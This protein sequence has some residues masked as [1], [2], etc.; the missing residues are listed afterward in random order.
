[1]LRFMLV[2]VSM[3]S[4]GAAFAGCVSGGGGSSG[5][6]G[7]TGAAAADVIFSSDANS[8]ADKGG[9]PSDST[10]S[11]GDSGNLAGETDGSTTAPTDTGGLDAAGA[12][13]G[14]ADQVGPNTAKP[15]TAVP[16][17]VAKADAAN[18]PDTSQ[19]ELAATGTAKSIA[20]IQKASVDCPT[21][22][23][24]SYGEMAGVTLT[25]V[26]VTSPTAAAGTTGKLVE[27][28]VQDKAGGPFSGMPVV[29]Q[30]A[31]ALGLVKPGDLLTLTGDVKDFYCFTQMYAGTVGLVGAGAA[32]PVAYPVATTDLGDKAGPAKTEPYEGVLVEFTNVVVGDDA[33][34]N[35][36]KPHGEVYIGQ[37]A[38]DKAVRLASAFL[39][40][41]L[42]DKT[43]GPSGEAVYTPKY[44]KGTKLGTVR[45]V[46]EYSFDTYRV[47]LTEDPLS[48]VKP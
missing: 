5:G 30:K 36:G 16:T 20:E 9:K 32:A 22:N 38:G 47:L 17:D 40:V 23:P 34:G 45:G 24:P 3:V 6:G 10:N 37:N 7:G 11:T 2:C 44:P 39:G 48:V 41:Y 21:P 1:M 25:E 33:L 43:T 35:D 13:P 18:A 8:L 46:V 29:G 26:V 4:L 27:V 42:A 15:D 14:V 12:D 19:Q 28:Y 31:G